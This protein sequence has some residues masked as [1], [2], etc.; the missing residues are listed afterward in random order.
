MDFRVSFLREIVVLGIV[1]PTVYAL[2][3]RFRP[4]REVMDTACNSARCRPMWLPPIWPTRA[5]PPTPLWAI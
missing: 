5:R 3:R 4:A 1:A 2:L